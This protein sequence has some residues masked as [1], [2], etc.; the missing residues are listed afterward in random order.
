MVLSPTI[1]CL[2]LGKETDHQ[3]RASARSPHCDLRDRLRRRFSAD[4]VS[5]QTGLLTGGSK[6]LFRETKVHYFREMR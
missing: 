3:V 1:S 5:L 6:H 2:E 4:R